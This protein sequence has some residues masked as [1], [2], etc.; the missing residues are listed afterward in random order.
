MIKKSTRHEGM[1]TKS[2]LILIG[3]AK[4]VGKHA[5]AK[6]IQSGLRNCLIINKESTSRVLTRTLMDM[7][8]KMPNDKS[9]PE[10]VHKVEPLEY[11]QLMT[12]V[13]HMLGFNKC[14]IVVVAQFFN[15]FSEDSWVNSVSSMC[16]DNGCKL[17]MIYLQRQSKDLAN[18]KAKHN[19]VNLRLRKTID[20]KIEIISNKNQI[21]K[22]STEEVFRKYGA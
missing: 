13:E 11:Q 3:G 5:L 22:Y 6:R 8:G 21:R 4:G 10:Y 20:T 16:N 2:K 1:A 17:E 14:N 15:Q 19:R 9:S 18:T 7:Y 12:T